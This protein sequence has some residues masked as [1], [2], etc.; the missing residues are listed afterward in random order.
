MPSAAH[1]PPAGSAK[2]PPGE[3]PPEAVRCWRLQPP[4]GRLSR[5]TDHCRSALGG[6]KSIVECVAT[7]EGE[8]L[9]C[10]LWLSFDYF[11]LS[12]VFFFSRGCSFSPFESRSWTLVNSPPQAIKGPPQAR[13]GPPQAK[14]GVRGSPPAQSTFICPALPELSSAFVRCSVRRIGVTRCRSPAPLP[15]A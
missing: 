7:R 9:L 10:V 4:V 8:I 15:R 3:G 6:A 11:F 12:G 13:K 1:T 5:R 2:R 14:R